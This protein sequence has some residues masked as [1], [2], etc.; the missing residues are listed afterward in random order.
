MRKWRFA[1]RQLASALGATGRDPA[2]IT[3]LADL[4]TP[5]TASLILRFYLERADGKPSAQT[6]ALA[7]HLKAIARA[8]V[9]VSSEGMAK[10]QRM[11]RKVTTPARGI[12]KNRATLRQ[13]ADP[14]QQQRLVTLPARLYAG[15]PTD[16]LPMRWALRLQL[17][18]RWSGTHS[19]AGWASSANAWHPARDRWVEAIDD[20]HVLLRHRP[21]S[22]SR[23]SAAFVQAGVITPRSTPL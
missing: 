7:A 23:R 5:E 14:R 8:H 9:A 22:I 3:S 16:P 1:I 10:L 20:L 18:R 17:P 13:F 4:V 11:A 19:R 12:H 2:Q 21:R 6:Q 15:L